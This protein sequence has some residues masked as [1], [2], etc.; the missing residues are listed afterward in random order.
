M[1]LSNQIIRGAK[2]HCVITIKQQQVHCT[3]LQWFALIT[4]ESI[5]RFYCFLALHPN[6]I[7][8]GLLAHYKSMASRKWK[9]KD[10]ECQSIYVFIPD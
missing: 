8:P 3:L 10:R 4:A 7:S 6:N 5:P 1:K 9:S 2:K